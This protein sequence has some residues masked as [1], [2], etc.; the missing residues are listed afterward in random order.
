VNFL[1]DHDVPDEISYV[2]RQLGHK[3]TLLRE[4]LAVATLDADIL[5]YAIREKLILISCNR[6]D[7]L[8]LAQTMPDHGII[9]LI[10]RRSRVAERAALLRLLERAGS[11]HAV[12]V[13]E[14]HETGL[15]NNIN[16]A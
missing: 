16:F 15:A 7:F 3:V 13:H 8:N 2:L 12:G 14:Y 4:V 5:G 6:D 1:L 11:V 9:V 10:R